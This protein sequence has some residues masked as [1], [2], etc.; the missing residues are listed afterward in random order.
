MKKLLAI[1]A[2]IT[3]ISL[4][5]TAHAQFFG[6]M[7]PLGPTAEHGIEMVGVYAGFATSTIGATGQV[8]FGIGSPDWDLGV[9]GGLAKIS[10]G[11]PTAFGAAVDLKGALARPAGNK[12]VALGG[13]LGVSFGHTGGTYSATDITISAVPG[14]SIRH[15]LGSGASVS[16]WA[17]VGFEWSHTS[18]SGTTVDG[19]DVSGGSSSGTSG[20]LRAGGEY[21][22]SKSMGIAAEFNHSFASGGGNAFMA[23]INFGMGGK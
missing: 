15:A 6:Q 23:G 20:V 19:V 11:G 14:V 9:Q 18:V 12:E 3:L 21:G 13:D 17:G 16:G 8:R 5:S 22:F 2:A 1:T 4:S 7:G 10:N